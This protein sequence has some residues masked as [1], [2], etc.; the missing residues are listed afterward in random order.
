M[1]LGKRRSRDCVAGRT[2]CSGASQYAVARQVRALPNDVRQAASNS[3]VS[4]ALVDYAART[5]DSFR[6][7]A[8]YV[9]PDGYVSVLR[10]R[11]GDGSGYIG[12]TAGE[13]II[14]RIVSDAGLPE[15]RTDE[16]IRQ[17]GD[18]F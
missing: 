1:S 3:D 13:T 11:R 15:S 2:D 4:Q 16:L 18:R 14:G 7:L 5:D 12:D 9:T 17:F 10:L 6:E 8:R